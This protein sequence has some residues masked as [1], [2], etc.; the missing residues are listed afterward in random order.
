MAAPHRQVILAVEAAPERGG[1][2]QV[3][4]REV[5][6]AGDLRAGGDLVV[7][8]EVCR[9]RHDVAPAVVVEVVHVLVDAVHVLVDERI[10]RRAAVVPVLVE[11]EGVA[12]A[13]VVAEPAVAQ[14]LRHRA[15][16]PVRGARVDAGRVEPQLRRPP[17]QA[18]KRVVVLP[19]LKRVA[20][21]LLGAQVD[22]LVVLELGRVPVG[23]AEAAAVH[24]AIVA[25]DAGTDVDARQ[26]RNGRLDC[27]APRLGDD[28]G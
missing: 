17:R 20:D 1:E 5:L 28:F 19:E 14:L 8:R 27:R 2:R 10:E 22:E 7:E 25:V 21:L 11:G 18:R 4:E 26:V 6:R 16:N 23:E 12:L 9:R 15:G 13:K 24:A 3:A